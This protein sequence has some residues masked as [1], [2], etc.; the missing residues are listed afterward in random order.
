MNK[1]LSIVIPSY[2][3]QD[4]L[5][6]CLDSLRVDDPALFNQLDII[7]VNDGSKDRT[8]A[9]AH[10]YVA[11]HPDVI[12]AIDKPNGNYGSCVNRGLAEAKGTFIKILDADDTFDMAAFKS[13]IRRLIESE[14]KNEQVDLF[15]TDFVWLNAAKRPTT[16]IRLD[17]PAE[18]VL[19]LDDVPH[20]KPIGMHAFTYRVH[21]LRASGYR[22]TEG[23]SYTDSEWTCYPVLMVKRLCYLPL[24]VYRYLTA[25]PGQTMEPERFY[26]QDLPMRRR[27]ALGMVA[28]L[29]QTGATLSPAA[30]HYLLGWALWMVE[31][32]YLSAIL[33]RPDPRTSAFLSAFDADV[34]RLA[35][36]FHAQLM[37]HDLRTG[38]LKL[39]FGRLW[40]CA[41]DTGAPSLRL[42][43]FY[44]RC[45]GRACGLAGRVKRLL[46]RCAGSRPAPCRLQAM[47]LETIG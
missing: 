15:L 19:A 30:H 43:R 7:V 44:L 1:I 2:N 16:R 29:A 41:R 31:G 3:M 5:P 47:L 9:I 10:E 20:L 21:M 38:L 4:Y 8:S 17:L 24:P 26:V 36:A 34:A 35:P 13:F 39:P 25:R 46:R 45:E 28:R 42:L 23:I 14:E 22:Q 27:V 12:R 32:V 40:A 18:K 33:I 11:Q 6:A 37:A